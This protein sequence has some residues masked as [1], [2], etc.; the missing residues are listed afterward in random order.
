MKQ[1]Y[2]V[3]KRYNVIGCNISRTTFAGAIRAVTNRVISGAGGYVC[4]TNVHAVVTARLNRNFRPVLE[5][6][7]MTMPDG[8]PLYWVA[9]VKRIKG[10]ENVPGPDFLPALM[11]SDSEQKL[12]HYFYG[13]RKEVVEQL[14]ENLK[15]RFPK[16]QIVGWESP[17]F[18]ELS[19]FEE[20]IA[21]QRILQSD[22][23]IVWVGLGAP[24]QELWMAD[25]A[26]R[27]RPALLMGVGAAFDFHAGHVARAPHWMRSIGMEWFH[28]LL[29]DPVRLWKRY[30]VTNSL[31]LFFAVFSR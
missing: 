31:F 11:E 25:H 28:R 19:A 9:K 26:E 22:A 18:R 6:S 15:V 24:K 27:L 12:R 1:Q 7:F 14:V 20:E 5:N 3:G 17:P 23:N 2:N 16:A 30:L 13:G 29:Q 4:F 21:M 10:V 8:K